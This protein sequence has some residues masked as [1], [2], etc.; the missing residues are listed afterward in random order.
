MIKNESRGERRISSYYRG[1]I[2]LGVV[3]IGIRMERRVPDL[4]LGLL[5]AMLC[6]TNQGASTGGGKVN[7]KDNTT[8]QSSHKNKFH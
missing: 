2:A 1:L 3:G 7:E 4:L 8:E 5:L 6:F